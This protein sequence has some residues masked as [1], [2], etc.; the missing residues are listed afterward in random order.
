MRALAEDRGRLDQAAR[1]LLDFRRAARSP[2]GR[3]RPGK[4]GRV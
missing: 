4:T 3:R 1:R 2:R